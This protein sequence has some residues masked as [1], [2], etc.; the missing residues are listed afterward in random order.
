MTVFGG[1]KK[2]NSSIS[3]YLC[4]QVPVD[5]DQATGTFSTANND[6]VQNLEENYGYDPEDGW[7]E[8]ER[9]AKVKIINGKITKNGGKQ[10]NGSPDDTIEF[11][12]TI[13]ADWVASKFAELSNEPKFADFLNDSFSSRSGFISFM[14]NEVEGYNDLLDPNSSDYWKVVSA[15]VKFMVYDDPSIRDDVTEDMIEYLR[16]N[17]DYASLSSYGIY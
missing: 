16:G 3:A 5:V 13:D 7:E 12:M 11:D 1:G 14:P 8:S 17:A 10:N 15:I 4:F 9:F 2:G 6:F